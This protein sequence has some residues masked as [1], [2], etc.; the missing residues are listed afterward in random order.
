MSCYGR[1]APSDSWK[2]NVTSGGSV[3]LREPNTEAVDLAIKAAAITGLEIAG[4]DLIYDL[5]KERYVV[6][7]VNAIPAFATPDQQQLGLDFNHNKVNKIVDLIE[8]KV[9]QQNT[10]NLQLVGMK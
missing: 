10:S 8:R 1:R 9:S 2:T 7:E 6:L 4:V 5:E 3:M